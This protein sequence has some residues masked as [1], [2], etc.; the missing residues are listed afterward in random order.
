[1]LL[2]DGK[3]TQTQADAANNMNHFLLSWKNSSEKSAITEAEMQT[4]REWKKAFE[5]SVT[6]GSGTIS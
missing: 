6:A 4:Y 5:G 2:A 3:L 1:M